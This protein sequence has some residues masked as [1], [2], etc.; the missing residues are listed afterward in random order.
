MKKL[1]ILLLVSNFTLSFAQHNE[2]IST[3]DFIEVLNDNHDETL[4]YYQNNWQQLRIKALEKGYI[5]NFELL[6]TKPTEESPYSFILIT[7]YANQEQYDQREKHFQELM[8]QKS[9]LKLL[10]DKQPKDFRQTSRGH[11]MVKHIK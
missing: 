3:I 7:T 2:R 6:E 11:D 8:A 9:G 5:N 1:L 10:N 4:F